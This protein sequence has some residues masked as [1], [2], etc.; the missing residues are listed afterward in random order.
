MNLP[1]IYQRVVA[2]RPEAAVIIGRSDPEMGLTTLH[3]HREHDS[4]QM[5]TS[6]GQSVGAR[7][8]DEAASLIESHWM[9]LLPEGYSMDR[10]LDNPNRRYSVSHSMAQTGCGYWTP[11]PTRLESLAAYLEAT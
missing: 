9:D 5:R 1:E 3:L 7:I 11:C 6:F 8:D 2:K 4:W 10:L